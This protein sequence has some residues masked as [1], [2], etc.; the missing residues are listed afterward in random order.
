MEITALKGKKK[1]RSVQFSC[2][3]MSDS[4]QPMDYSTPGLPLHHKLLEFTQIHVH[5]V[6]DAIQTSHPLLPLSPPPLTLSQHQGLFYE[7]ALCISSLHYSVSIS[8]SNEYSGL[9]S[10]RIEWFDLLAVKGTLK[11]LLQH[12]SWKAS[13]LWHSAFFMV[14]LYNHTW[15][16][17]KHTFDWT[18]LCWQNSVSAF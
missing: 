13:V 11:S 1:K 4:L 2:S 15:L 3:V 7:S 14:Q 18:D 5:W 8:P 17:E 6:S 12:H 10:F 9:I 16:L